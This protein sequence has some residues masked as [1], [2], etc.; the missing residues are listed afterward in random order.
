MDMNIEKSI[1]VLQEEEN[2]VMRCLCEMSG[3]ER[4]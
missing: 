2:C 4:A 1:R 3:N